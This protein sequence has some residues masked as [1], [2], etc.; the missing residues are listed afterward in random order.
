MGGSILQLHKHLVPSPATSFPR[1]PP[2][3]RWRMPGQHERPFLMSGGALHRN[4]AHSA[5]YHF[6]EKKRP[7]PQ[8]SYNTVSAHT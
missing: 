3:Q 6:T 4:P 1:K 8:R 5:F 2:A 7:R